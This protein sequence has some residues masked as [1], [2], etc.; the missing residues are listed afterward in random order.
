MDN[1]D[2]DISIGIGL[3]LLGGF[4]TGIIALIVLALWLISY[5]FHGADYKKDLPEMNKKFVEE[6]TEIGLMLCDLVEELECYRRIH[7]AFR[8]RPIGAPCSNTRKNQEYEIA[9]EDSAIS[10][11]KRA[12]KLIEKLKGNSSF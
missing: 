4:L 10:T 12:N 3:Y 2:D 6:R 5:M 8:N 7:P 11:V 1:D 9:L